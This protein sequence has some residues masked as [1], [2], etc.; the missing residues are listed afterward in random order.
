VKAHPQ[1]REAVAGD[2]IDFV[3]DDFFQIVFSLSFGQPKI[4]FPEIIRDLQRFDGAQNVA[5][6]LAENLGNFQAVGCDLSVRNGNH[7]GEVADHLFHTKAQS[8]QGKK[9]F[10]VFC[11]SF[12]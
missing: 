6:F 3:A 9:S 4:A 12:R 2:V 11:R 8:F 1:N 7:I 5:V 10:P